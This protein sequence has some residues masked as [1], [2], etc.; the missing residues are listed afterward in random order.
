M[1]VEGLDEKSGRLASRTL[2][3]VDDQ[4]QVRKVLD[5][6]LSG[7]GATV[8][9]A[10]DGEEGLGLVGSHNPHL[11]LL[12]L[13]MPGLD[14]WQF[15]ERLPSAAR[16]PEPP[17]IL[18]TSADDYASLQRA[19]RMGVAAYVSK[20]F[21]MNEVVETCVRVL[22]GSWPLQGRVPAAPQAARVFAQGSDGAVMAQGDLLELASHGAQ[23][24]LDAALP[25]G[26]R[27]RFILEP[28]QAGTAEIEAEVR[29]VRSVSGRWIHGLLLQP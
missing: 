5:S 12:D 22:S 20:P 18:E 26:R 29:W 19:R 11:I 21:R 4:L 10:E 13:Y 6:G 24:D 15:L 1:E 3:V 7:A 27:F 2:L 9:T 23:V 8:I 28:A 17:V 25:L 16:R 14:G